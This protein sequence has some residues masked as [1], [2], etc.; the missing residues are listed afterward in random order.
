MESSFVFIQRSES[1]VNGGANLTKRERG[2]NDLYVFP[3]DCNCALLLG[4]AVR[5]RVE[6]LENQH[7]VKFKSLF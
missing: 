5:L 6:E 2:T 4:D 1:A 3:K 7:R